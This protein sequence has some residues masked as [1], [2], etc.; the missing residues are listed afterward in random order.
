VTEPG[1]SG[2][3]GRLLARHWSDVVATADVP[4]LQLDAL[5][6]G[7]P[8]D[9]SVL[10]RLAA[11]L[12]WHTADLFVVAG[13]DLP[14]DLV[15]ASDTGPWHV[16]SVLEDAVRL[17]RDSLRR[18]HETIR[19]LP[20]HRPSWPP[21]PPLRSY[22][23]G[24]GEVL[25]RLLDNRNIR[26]YAA[27][28]LVMVGDGP[29]VSQAT[30][31]ML[32]PGRVRLTPRYITAFAAVLG[33]P[34]DDLAAVT[35]VAAATDLDRHPAHAELARLAWDAR[36]LTGEQLAHVLKVAGNLRPR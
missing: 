18:L 29:Y 33:V 28:V 10:R 19:S 25:L 3:L 5:L 17:T 22:P 35:G 23:L 4:G 30:V 16:G 7:G 21:T 34:A 8:A 24:P 12:G 20:E 31:A 13:L 1:F 15:P 36:R 11:P 14:E 32:G 26:R 27:K 2:G 9:P 6:T